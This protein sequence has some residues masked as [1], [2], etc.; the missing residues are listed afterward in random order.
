M[1]KNRFVRVSVWLLGG[2]GISLLLS[3]LYYT[4]FA[5]VFSTDVEAYLAEENRLYSKFLPEIE[6]DADLMDA[7]IDYLRLR[8]E[9]I[10]RQ[11]FK[12]EPSREEDM[13]DYDM[14]GFGD[15]YISERE[16]VKQSNLQSEALMGRA[17]DIDSFWREITDSLNARRF[18]VPPMETPVKGLKYNNV[19][20]SIGEKMNPFYKVSVYHDGLDIVAPA[21]TG[22]CATAQGYVREVRKSD[23]GSGNT[24]SIE[25]ENGYVTTYSHLAEVSV[26]KGR[27]VSRGRKIGTVGDSGRSFTTHLHYSV[28]KDG[29]YLDPNNYFFGS[30]SPEEYMKFMIMSSSSGQSMD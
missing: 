20:A 25:H 2:F 15:G 21:G 4:L 30:I 16:L 3:L 12:A 9:N 27:Y 28:Q 8:D 5:L 10:Y 23:G 24:V 26:T 7:E 17:A 19:G 11:I 14:S 29:E 1:I 18:F 22:V 13:M 6:A